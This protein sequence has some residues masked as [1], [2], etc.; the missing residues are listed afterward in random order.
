VTFAIYADQEGGA[1]LWMET[2]NVT[3]DGA[4]RYTALLGGESSDG[5]PLE[6]FITGQARWLGSKARISSNLLECC[7]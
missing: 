3:F 1:A 6:L 5:V 7:W 2:Q 4:G